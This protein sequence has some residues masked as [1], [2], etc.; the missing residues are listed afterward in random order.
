M[1]VNARHHCTRIRLH[2]LSIIHFVL[3]VYARQILGLKIGRHGNF[4]WIRLFLEVM[5]S[6]VKLKKDTEGGSMEPIAKRQKNDRLKMLRLKS[7]KKSP[8]LQNI[9]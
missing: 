2:L 5:G 8:F 4:Y 3:Y 9:V 6:G 1:R 7:E